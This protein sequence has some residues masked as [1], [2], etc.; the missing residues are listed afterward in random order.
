MPRARSPVDNVHAGGIAARVDIPTG[1]LSKATDLGVRPDSQWHAHHPATG[2]TIEG[3]VLPFWRE[4]LDLARRAHSEAFGD[5]L[6][7]GWDIGLT[8][9]GP[10]LVEGNIG[11]DVDGVQRRSRQPLGQTRLGAALAH[12]LTMP[13]GR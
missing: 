3:R 13:V 7:V 4:T 5:L 9:D 11:P 10:I 8:D 6:M 12:L 2:A 1:R